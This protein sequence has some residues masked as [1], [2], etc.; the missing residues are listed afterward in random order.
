[1][2]KLDAFLHPVEV[3][4]T[5]EVIISKRFLDE[6]GKP[7]PF[8]IRTISGAQNDALRSACTRK[9]RDRGVAYEEFDSDSY[10]KK[11]LLSCVVEPDFSKQE[12]CAAY[13]TLDPMEVPGKM[14]LAGEMNR[15]SKAIS[16]FNGFGG[17]DLD[18]E[19]KNF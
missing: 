11:L 13:G 14:L 4:Q 15:L 9:V 10:A 6:K 12:L 16:D 18:E 1:M 17:D 3:E 7:A 5:R 2:S 19:A 8:V